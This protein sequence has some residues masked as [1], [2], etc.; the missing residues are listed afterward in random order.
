MRFLS[1]LLSA[2]LML[3]ANDT[4]PLSLKDNT[5]IKLV[6]WRNTLIDIVPNPTTQTP[7]PTLLLKA[8]QTTLIFEKPLD[9]TPKIMEAEGQKVIV[10]KGVGMD[11]KKTMDFSLASLKSLEAF[12]YQNDLYL[13]SQKTTTPLDLEI[14]ASRSKDSKQ[15]RFLFIPKGF[16]LISQTPQK[17]PQ[18]ELKEPIAPKESIPTLSGVSTTPKA[19]QVLETPKVHVES[20]LSSLGLKA[21]LDLS[22][23]YKALGVILALLGVLYFVKKKFTPKE[24]SLAKN[25]KLEINTLKQI[26][27]RHKIIS[28]DIEWERYLVLLSDKHSLLLGKTNIKPSKEALIKEAELNVKNSKLGNLYARYF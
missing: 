23:A 16:S 8:V 19:H 3:L 13:L 12:S 27:A 17:K 28:I 25:S 10:L 6:D 20:P 5:P 7:T 2:I 21:P 26:D 4:E 22:H 11:S 15:V 14:Q 18:I 1:L 9:T 24:S